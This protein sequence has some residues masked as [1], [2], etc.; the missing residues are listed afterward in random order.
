MWN[1]ARGDCDFF[2][3]V[4][5]SPDALSLSLFLT[6]FRRATERGRFIREGSASRSKLLPFCV[7]FLI[8]KVPLSYNFHRKWFPIFIYL[9]NDFYFTF[10][11]NNLLNTWM[12]QP[13]SASLRDIFKAPLFSQ[14]ISILQLVKSL[15][16]FINPPEP[17]SGGA[18]PYIPL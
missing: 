17:L 7:P 16:P 11:L 14:P 12:N 18:F 3:K 15:Y 1:R 6:R 10:H 2:K 9:Q 4:R 5:A 13:L 8:E